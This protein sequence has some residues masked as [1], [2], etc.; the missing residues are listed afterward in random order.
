[1]NKL[2]KRNFSNLNIIDALLFIVWPNKYIIKKSNP[3]NRFSKAHKMAGFIEG[4]SLDFDNKNPICNDLNNTVLCT[5]F[6]WHIGGAENILLDFL[7]ELKLQDFKIIDT[8][9]HGYGDAGILFKRFGKTADSQYILDEIA[10]G[11]FPRL[12]ALWEIIK[13]EKPKI[14]LNMSNPYLYILSPLIKK[15]FPNT[16][17]YDLLHCED[18]D[19]NGWFEAAYQYQ[20]NIDRRIV[21]SH[22]WKDVLIQKYNEK[23]EKIDVVYNMINYDGFSNMKYTR[24]ELLTK[25]KIDT[26]KKIIGFIGRFEW[27]KRP[28]IFVKLADS[29]KTNDDFHFVMVGEGNMYSGL[30]TKIKSLTNLTYLGAT[31]NPETVYPMFDIAIFPSKYEGYPLVGIECAHIGLPIIASNIVGFREQI[32]NGKFGLLYDINGDDEDVESIKNLLLTSYDELIKLGK[33]G[34]SFIN[35]YHNEK[36][37]KENIKNVFVN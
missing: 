32:N 21:T 34:T 11:P 22:F 26:K 4:F 31:K 35:E 37:I 19:D 13:Q 15:K 24:N 18:Y 33:N 3:I 20:N 12:V 2:L 1:M 14:I 28:D 23:P 36:I 30:E 9:A 17:I 16:I 10:H 6:W 29:M 5:H 25:N 27:Q 7:K 8:A